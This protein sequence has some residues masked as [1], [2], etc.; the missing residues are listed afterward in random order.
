[1]RIHM[2]K[3]RRMGVEIDRRVLKETSGNRGLLVVRDV[4]DQGLRRPCKVARLLQGDTILSELND[5]HIVWCN[6]G[7]LTLAG[8]ERQKNEAGQPVDYAQSWLCILDNDPE[9][10]RGP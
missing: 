9:A 6:D 10:I 1:M 4:T 3:M 7:R 5:V 2:V 8:F